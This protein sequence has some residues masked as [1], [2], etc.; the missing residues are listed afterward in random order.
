MHYGI[1]E[2]NNYN[3]FQSPYD[4]TSRRQWLLHKQILW[5]RVSTGRRQN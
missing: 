3:A 4:L 5:K 1:M 2:L